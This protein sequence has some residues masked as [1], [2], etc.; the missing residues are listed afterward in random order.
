MVVIGPL[1]CDN[2]GHTPSIES[3][4]KPHMNS[5]HPPCLSEVEGEQAEPMW[6]NFLPA[7]M[8]GSSVRLDEYWGVGPKTSTQLETTLGTEGAITAI[9]S[10]DTAALVDAGL[11]RGR[12]TRILRH[13]HGEHGMAML[14]TSDTRAVYKDLL[15]QDAVEF[16][17]RK[18]PSC[19]LQRPARTGVRVR[20]HRARPRPNPRADT[21]H[22][23]RRH[24][25]SSRRRH[26]RN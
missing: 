10:T 11:P 22:L 1:P 5:G 17:L 14:A 16:A 21:A 4:Q 9:E 24:G 15:E 3:I 12:A 18:K 19:R 6:S 23:D 13:S 26:P 2:S 25:G 8:D 7:R 20:D